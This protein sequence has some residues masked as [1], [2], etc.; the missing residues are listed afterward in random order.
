MFTI[1]DIVILAALAIS[2]LGNIWYA[3]SADHYETHL[4]KVT[5]SY[6]RAYR[7]LAAGSEKEAVFDALMRDLDHDLNH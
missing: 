2:F 3:Y 1:I 5:D 6:I 7:D 4:K